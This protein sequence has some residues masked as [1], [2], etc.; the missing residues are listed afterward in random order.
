MLNIHSKYSFKYGLKS[1]SDIVDWAIENGYRRIA[2]TDINNSGS[3][4]SFIQYAQQQDFLPVVG[5]DVRNDND[6]CY[7]IIAQNNRGFHEMNVFLSNY[8]NKKF[9]ERPDFLP[10]C[11]IIYSWKKRPEELK[12][13]ERIGITFREIKIQKVIH[14]P[15][16]ENM[17][18]LHTMTFETKKDFNVHR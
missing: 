12:N 4:L 17:V 10:N 6:Q 1:P 3:A 8:L 15:E 9:P 11:Y 16:F 7:V 18:A 5:V 2:L 14:D 13:N